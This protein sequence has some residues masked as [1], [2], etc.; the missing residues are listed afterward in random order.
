VRVSRNEFQTRG[1]VLRWN[2]LVQLHS[3]VANILP[4]VKIEAGCRDGLTRIFGDL[5]ELQ[6]FGNPQRRA[7]EKLRFTAS[8]ESFKDHLTLSLAARES[9]N[10]W[11]SID[12]SQDNGEQ[13]SELV[14]D[15]LDS[16]APWFYWIAKLNWYWLLVCLSLA[17][18]IVVPIVMLMARRRVTL[19]FGNWRI[20]DRGEVL[21]G[22]AVGLAPSIIGGLLNL[23]RSQLFPMGS[24]AFGHG[25]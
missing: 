13:L 18:W 3:R 17:A 5:D 9:R 1:F 23:V 12:A 7:I 11:L 22:L 16:I 15:T 4:K 25:E 21:L 6:R 8:D 20:I 2:D 19:E 10:V 24:F 14:N